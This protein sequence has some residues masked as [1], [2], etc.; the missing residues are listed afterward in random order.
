MKIFVQKINVTENGMVA[1]QKIKCWGKP[2][3]LLSIGNV[4]E[5]K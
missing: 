4:Y 3:V 1:L 5:I 2:V